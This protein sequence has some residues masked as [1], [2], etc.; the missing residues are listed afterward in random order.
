MAGCSMRTWLGASMFLLGELTS[1]PADGYPVRPPLI[2]ATH[3]PDL[4]HQY[5][6]ST[7]TLN[8]EIAVTRLQVQVEG[9]GESCSA[10]AVITVSNGT[11]SVALSVTTLA[12][13][14]GPVN[15]SFVAGIPITVSVSVPAA[16]LYG[17]SWANVV[18]QYTSQDRETAWPRASR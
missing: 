10:N 15:A 3:V 13:D 16:C 18:V 7:L 8:E 2:W 17:P 14:T 4:T 9:Q 5:T 11:A 12:N 1:I 6:A